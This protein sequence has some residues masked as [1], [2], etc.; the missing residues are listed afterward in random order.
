MPSVGPGAIS[1]PYARRAVVNELCAYYRRGPQSSGRKQFAEKGSKYFRQIRAEWTTYPE[2][3]NKPPVRALT[4]G[5]RARLAT[6][7][8][9]GKRHYRTMGRISGAA[10]N[11][12]F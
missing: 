5:D 3:Y 11:A 10:R 12:G 1:S 4:R 8:R 6:F 9:Y 2:T 7:K